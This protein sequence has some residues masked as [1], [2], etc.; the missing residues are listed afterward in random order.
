MVDI[1]KSGF[2]KNDVFFQLIL[3]HGIELQQSA[4]S[5]LTKN[6]SKNQLIDYK[7]ALNQFTIDLEVA[8]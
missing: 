8:G 5:Y 1:D 3:L 6:Y 4:I 2:V 7:E